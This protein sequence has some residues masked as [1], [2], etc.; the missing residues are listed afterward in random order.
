MINYFLLKLEN[1]FDNMT[2]YAK[3]MIKRCG[4]PKGIYSIYAKPLHLAK[5][6][7]KYQVNTG[8]S[9][10]EW[11]E[12]NDVKAF[13][14]TDFCMPHPEES[15]AYTIWMMRLMQEISLIVGKTDDLDLYKEY[16]LG[17]KKA[18]QEL[19]TKPAFSLDTDRQA[20]L[21]RPLYLDLLMQKE[22]IFLG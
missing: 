5:E 21:V 3:F 18:Y 6:N 22:I 13:V 9:Y 4:H 10:G 19:V 8:Q 2:R 1:N 20:K 7:R 15:M 14:W 12:P 16:E 17:I 11:A